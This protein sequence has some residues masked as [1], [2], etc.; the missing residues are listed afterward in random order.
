MTVK[1]YLVDGTKELFETQ[2][3]K[4]STIKDLHPMILKVEVFADGKR[5]E[6]LYRKHKFFYK[7]F[8][9]NTPKVQNLLKQI[10]EQR[11]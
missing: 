7:H 10:D 4:I 9:F 3:Y 8:T 6:K 11:T 5:I 2:N 1:T